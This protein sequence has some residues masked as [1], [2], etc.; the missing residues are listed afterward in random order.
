MAESAGRGEGEEP[1]LEA[2]LIRRV[3]Q[4]CA[5]VARGQAAR[6]KWQVQLQRVLRI[7]SI[8]LSSLGSAGIIADRVYGN[9]PGQTGWAFTGSVIVL[10]FGI[11]LQI[12]NEFRIEQDASDA[13]ALAEACGQFETQLDILLGSEDPTAVVAQLH[14]QVNA[15]ILKYH[16]VL[17]AVTPEL[18]AKATRLAQRLVKDN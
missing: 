11:V 17:P 16:R 14:E 7:V 13:R 4:I 18:E 10:G 12:A 8:I 6:G 1:I 2:R 15:V 3:Q 5:R 9:V